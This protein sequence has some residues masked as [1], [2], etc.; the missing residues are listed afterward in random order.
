MRVANMTAVPDY[1]PSEEDPKRL[2]IMRK[3]HTVVLK[4]HMG[5]C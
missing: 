5:Y 3:A 2:P 1:L 4:L